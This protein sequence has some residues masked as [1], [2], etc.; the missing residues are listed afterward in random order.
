MNAF[1]NQSGIELDTS[2]SRILTPAQCE[3]LAKKAAV[4][5]DV[6]PIVAVS[7]WIRFSPKKEEEIQF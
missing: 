2:G 5:F 7:V 6:N 1:L 3:S 4:I